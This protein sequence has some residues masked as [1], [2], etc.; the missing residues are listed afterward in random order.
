MTTLLFDKLFPEATLVNKDVGELPSILGTYLALRY[1]PPSV[2]SL[3]RL[4]PE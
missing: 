4:K 2:E 3:L 1:L